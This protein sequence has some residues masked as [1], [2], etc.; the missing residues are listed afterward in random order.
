MGTDRGD[1]SGPVSERLADSGFPQLQAL[2]GGAGTRLS[3]PPDKTLENNMLFPLLPGC[4]RAVF[5][6]GERALYY[7]TAPEPPS[8]RAA[9]QATHRQR[10]PVA[11]AHSAPSPLVSRLRM[12]ACR[13]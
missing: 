3:A 12:T 7:C 13:L 11:R 8:L 1:D 4:A 5:T 10:S 2:W 9:E 6:V